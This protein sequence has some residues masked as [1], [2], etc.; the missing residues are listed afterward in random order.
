MSSVATAMVQRG[1][2]FFLS[3]TF[4]SKNEVLSVV[5]MLVFSIYMDFPGALV[6]F[7]ASEDKSKLS[8]RRLRLRA[9]VGILQH[10]F[11]FILHV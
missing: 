3:M 10:G 11:V 6:Y 1:H 9:Y 8:L 2:S 5:S 7:Q 4:L